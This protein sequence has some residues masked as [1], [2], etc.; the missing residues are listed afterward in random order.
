MHDDLPPAED[1]RVEA[2]RRGDVE[3]LPE[4]LRALGAAL[5]TADPERIHEHEALAGGVGPSAIE[6]LVLVAADPVLCQEDAAGDGWASIRATRL[7]RELGVRE[8]VD[9]DGIGRLLDALGRLDDMDILYTDLTYALSEAG[10]VVVEPALAR[11]PA[12]LESAYAYALAEILAKSD[13]R[14]ERI[15]ELLLRFFDEDVD[16][17]ASLFTRYGDPRALPHLSAALDEV[18]LDDEEGYWEQTV[19]ELAFAIT[20]L[21]G[22]LTEDQREKRDAVRKR[23]GDRRRALLAEREQPMVRAAPKVGRNDPCPCGS[24]T[25]YKKCHGKA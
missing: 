18:D 9:G 25:K 23:R 8:H 4:E 7:L 19:I 13:T 12:D 2:L 3:A 14:D 16:L 1:A 22:E 5:L 20:R 17:G 10:E 24:G 11:L 6:L 15:L 21:G